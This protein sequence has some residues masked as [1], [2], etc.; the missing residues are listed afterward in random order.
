[1]ALRIRPLK[2]EELT[3]GYKAVATKVDDK[4][5]MLTMIMVLV[6]VLG[7][8]FVFVVL[9][10]VMVMV[11]VMVIAP[12]MVLVSVHGKLKVAKQWCQGW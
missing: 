8:V 4:V 5:R 6:V 2:R 10:F 7:M 1:M 11:L 12:V 9:V 3:R